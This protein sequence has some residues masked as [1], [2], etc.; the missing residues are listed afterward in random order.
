MEDFSSSPERKGGFFSVLRCGTPT[1][2]GGNES[3]DNFLPGWENIK[4]RERQEGVIFGFLL[5]GRFVSKGGG[6]IS[7]LKKNLGK[8]EWGRG[9]L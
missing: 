7:I 4:E 9:M 8:E 2:W 3:S 6:T 5:K 1:L